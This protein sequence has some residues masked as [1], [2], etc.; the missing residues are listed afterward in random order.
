MSK[1]KL[2]ATTG[3]GATSLEAPN[4][5]TGNANVSWKLPVA[6]GSNGQALTTNASGQLAFST[7]AGGKILQV[8]VATST[9]TDQTPS[10]NTAWTQVGP[11]VTITPA[12]SSNKILVCANAWALFKNIGNFGHTIYRTVGGSDADVQ[13]WWGEGGDDSWMPMNM[14]AFILDSPST[15]SEISYKQKIYCTTNY[16]QFRFNYDVAADPTSS[17][18]AIEVEA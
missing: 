7:V 6:D 1:V 17:L 14:H 10:G 16:T 8:Q 3:G 15:T 18:I 5:T 9:T 4:A 12:S 2:T 13:L 11:T